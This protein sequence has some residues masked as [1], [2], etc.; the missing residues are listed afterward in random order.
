M[1]PFLQGELRE[2]CR[3][4]RQWPEALELFRQATA[5]DPGDP[6]ALVFLGQALERLR[7]PALAPQVYERAAAFDPLCSRP[8][9][10]LAVLHRR[11]AEQWAFAAAALNPFAPDVRA[12]P[13]P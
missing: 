3:W 8:P 12:S 7:R 2:R 4:R 13:F 10:A 1:W 6:Y 11:R 9:R 5:A